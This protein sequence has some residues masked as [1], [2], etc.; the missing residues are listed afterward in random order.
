MN[1]RALRAYPRGMLDRP[2]SRRTRRMDFVEALGVGLYPD[3][4]R[5][6]SAE[7]FLRATHD[8]VRDLT[9]EALVLE[10]F[11]S[12]QRRAVESAARIPPSPWLVER[13]A[14]LETEAERRRS[15]ATARR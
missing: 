13:I 12:L 14:R 1:P 3:P 4:K 8:D 7:S 10:R 2:V 15:K 11:L 9:D 5:F 6:D